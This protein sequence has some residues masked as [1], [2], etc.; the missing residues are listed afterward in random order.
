MLSL[1]LLVASAVVGG[2]GTAVLDVHCGSGRAPPAG[3]YGSVTAA[4]DAI[5][6]QRQ[7]EGAA[8]VQ[9]PVTV[10]IVGRCP[11]PLVLDAGVGDS[12]VRWVG[13]GTGAAIT[14]GLALPAAKFTAVTD[15]SALQ[16]LPP[17]T[18]GAC[19]GASAQHTQMGAVASANPRMPM[20]T[21][22]AAILRGFHPLSMSSSRRRA[23]AHMIAHPHRS[24]R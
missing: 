5:R 20:R 23:R 10:K 7:S 11:G 9:V 13:S 15:V 22:S 4:R 1:A 14:G 17:Q 12:A 18:A 16:A 21:Q 6:R 2:P 8:K 24:V 19:A 3:A